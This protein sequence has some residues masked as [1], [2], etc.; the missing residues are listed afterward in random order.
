VKGQVMVRKQLCKTA[1]RQDAKIDT[2]ISDHEILIS[3]LFGILETPIFT[4]LQDTDFT[5]TAKFLDLIFKGKLHNA[6]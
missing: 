4:E 3:S 2:N 5:E 6:G 1:K